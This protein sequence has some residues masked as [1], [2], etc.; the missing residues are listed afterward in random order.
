MNRI[1]AS[2]ANRIALLG[3]LR[4][5]AAAAA[6]SLIFT[7]AGNPAGAMFATIAVL[8]LS[9]ADAGGPY[10]QRLT[11]MTA[12]ALIVP[13]ILL[14]GMQT[15]AVW[16]LAVAAMFL[17]AMLGG[18]ARL[19]GSAGTAIGLI[20]SIVF[21]IATEVPGSWAQSLQFAGCYFAGA[22]WT[23]VVV[24]VIWRVHPFRRIR[25][26][27]GEC[28]LKLA[29]EFRLLRR[30]CDAPADASESGLAA[31]QSRVREAL[32]QVRQSIGE[33]VLAMESVP[34]FVSDLVV[35][36]RAAAR[37]N[38]AAASLGG[39]LGL[40]GS[41]H[42]PGAVRQDLRDLLAGFES[43]CLEVAAAVL[44]QGTPKPA[45]GEDGRQ[46]DPLPR[47]E[48]A[49]GD[50]PALE[51]AETFVNIVT[52]QLAGARRVVERMAGRATGTGIL[53][54]LYG[55]S[56]P[57]GGLSSLRANLTFQSIVFRHAVRVAA[58]TAIGLAAELW[59]RLPH[60]VWAPLTVLIVLQPHLGATVN[61]ALHRTGGTIA[62]ALVA[63]VLV[64][65]FPGGIGMQAA[66]LA[67]LFLTLL[68]FR[69]RYWIAVVFLT[70]MII[71]LLTQQV[72]NP[73]AEITERIVNTLAGAALALV[74][75]YLLWP[76]WEYRR[77]PEQTASSLDAA[78]RYLSAVL[79]AAARG[80]EPDW[81]LARIRSGAELAAGNARASLDRLLTEPHRSRTER[82][83]AVAMVTYVE[84]LVRHVTRLSIYLH[85]KPG[86]VFP[87]GE[88]AGVLDRTLRV[89]ADAVRQG[90]ASPPL[91][92]LEPAYLSMRR[93]WQADAAALG[94]DW[95][96]VDSLTGSIVADLNSLQEATV[97]ET[98]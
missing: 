9:I 26:E 44:D 52:R 47:I 8:N 69:R 71:L 60:G 75:G 67:C 77:L 96:I 55:P 61:K 54:P 63:A 62:G 24:M 33:A 87:F 45:P 83:K 64:Y 42:L 91:E 43:E 53:P 90:R 39:A 97:G 10:R 20:S 1:L 93:K 70:P 16:W 88:L 31:A 2:G 81:P 76:S 74:A 32:G 95:R 49:T 12:I 98:P 78:D 4:G 72:A 36:L 68:F 82:R 34:P 25:Y 80:T 65:L 66:I 15:Q 14:A 94:A 19:F 51:E 92:E 5:T 79:G 58:A 37:T 48:L 56:F 11:V 38:A 73:W 85:E 89:I 29:G 18:L 40:S 3:A 84:R 59:W 35:L 21:L 41:T 30:Y 22:A 86:T 17:V 28:F 46:P 13:L 50:D 6:P 57:G 7:A 23:I 27:L